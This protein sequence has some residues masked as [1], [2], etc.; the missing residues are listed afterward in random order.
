MST[1]PFDTHQVN[2]YADSLKRQVPGFSSLHLM[3]S[4]L[5]GE[6]VPENGRVLVL[7]AGG[8][9]E[10][11]SLAELHPEWT[12]VGVEPSE[13]MMLL[14][15]QTVARFGESITFHEGYIDQAPDGP[16]DGATSILVFHFI[17]R[18]QRHETLRQVRLRLKPGAPFV[19]VHLSFP[20]EEP[21]RS[22]WIARHVA[23][24]VANGNDPANSEAACEAI[25]DKLTIL[26]PEDDVSMLEQAGFSN[27]TLFH[28]GLSIRGWVAY[29]A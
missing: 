2:N 8:G 5:L 26:S 7:G 17:D 13:Q 4:M 12:F 1:N 20:Q 25:A 29:A 16:F 23:F 11:K 3:I 24:G 18:V 10:L 19:L 22:G 9:Q 15:R 6:C 28:M 21:E 27:V 14:A